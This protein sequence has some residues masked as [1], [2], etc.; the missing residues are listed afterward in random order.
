L[1][2]QASFAHGY[3]AIQGVFMNFKLIVAVFV[4]VAAPVV[5]QA[6][7]S[8][9]PTMADVQKVVQIV[10]ADKAKTKTYCDIVKLYG[11]MDAL[12][13]KKDK[14]KIDELGSQVDA[15]EPT[16]GPEYVS[17]TGKLQQLN[18]NSKESKDL[19][20]ALD[21]LDKLCSN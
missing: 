9:K 12:D 4:L 20:T 17:L 3:T 2:G 5:A 18:S 14:K 11:Q 21:T 7:K 6:Q 13:Q 1:L 19:V 16:L 8:T 10:S 15:L